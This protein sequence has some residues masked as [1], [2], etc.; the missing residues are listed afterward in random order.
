MSKK[1]WGAKPIL[2]IHISTSSKL[3]WFSYKQIKETSN[4][5][6]TQFESFLTDRIARNQEMSCG[7]RKSEDGRKSQNLWQWKWRM[8]AHFVLFE[9]FELS[10]KFFFNC[11]TRDMPTMPTR[12]NFL[13]DEETL[14]EP[15]LFWNVGVKD[16]LGCCED[17]FLFTFLGRMQGLRH[18]FA[19]VPIRLRGVYK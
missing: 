8:G 19:L 4:C 13:F 7:L 17:S 2:R 9:I 12:F 10:K 3:G 6:A 14:F 1:R 15:L 18:T 16:G 5:T 11:S